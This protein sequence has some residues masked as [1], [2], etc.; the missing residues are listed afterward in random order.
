M[1]A[2]QPEYLLNLPNPKHLP[3]PHFI[4]PNTYWIATASGQDEPVAEAAASEDWRTALEHR[5]GEAFDLAQ[6]MLV[7]LRSTYFPASGSAALPTFGDV[8]MMRNAILAALRDTADFGLRYGPDGT[9]LLRFIL[10]RTSLD[11]TTTA[12]IETALVALT[13]FTLDEWTAL[14]I[15]CEICANSLQDAFSQPPTGVFASRGL[16]THVATPD[17]L[18]ATLDMLDSIQTALA[19]DSTLATVLLN[20][21][22]DADPTDFN[23]SFPSAGPNAT[24]KTVVAAVFDDLTQPPQDQKSVRTSRI[25]RRRMLLA[26]MGTGLPASTSLPIWM[27]LINTP[28]TGYQDEVADVTANLQSLL[29]SYFRGRF[30]ITLQDGNASL[31][32]GRLPSANWPGTATLPAPDLSAGLK[33]DAGTFATNVLFPDPDDQSQRSSHPVILQ[34]GDTTDAAGLKPVNDNERKVAGVGLLIREGNGLWTCADIANLYVGE[35]SNA[36][37]FTQ[38]ALDRIVPIRLHTRNKLKQP[39]LSYNNASL[40]TQEADPTTQTFAGAGT[41]S[42][43]ETTPDWDQLFQFRLDWNIFGNAFLGAGT[44]GQ[45]LFTI[46]SYIAP[47]GDNTDDWKR[48]PALKFGSTYSFLPFVIGNSGVLPP[49]LASLTNPFDPVSPRVFANNWPGWAGYIR[50]VKYLRRIGVGAPRIRAASADVQQDLPAIPP[51][52]VPLARDIDADS[53]TPVLLLYD[54]GTT[55]NVTS[56]FKLKLRPPACDLETWDRWVAGLGPTYRNTRIAI[57]TAVTSCTAKSVS[58][59]QTLDLSIDDPAVT[60]LVFS[61]V[62]VYPPPTAADVVN[63]VPISMPAL[64]AFGPSIT[65]PADQVLTTLM[66]PV[67]FDG[68]T[69][70]CSIDPTPALTPSGYGVIVTIPEGQVWKLSA[71]V[72]VK[73]AGNFEGLAAANLTRSFDLLIEAASADV[74]APSASPITL[75]TFQKTLCTA[76]QISYANNQLQASLNPWGLP[77]DAN[78]SRDLIR[79]IDLRRQ[80]WRWMGRPIAPLPA[81]WKITPPMSLLDA[82]PPDTISPTGPQCSR[83]WEIGSFAERPDEDSAINET[84]VNFAWP[85]TKSKAFTAI[86]LYSSDLTNDPRAQYFRF[87]IDVHSRYEGLPGFAVLPVRAQLNDATGSAFTRWMRAVVPPRNSGEIPKPKVLLILPLTEPDSTQSSALPDLLVIANEEWFAIGGLAEELHAELDLA[88]DPAVPLST[89]TANANPIPEL[90]PN[91]ILTATALNSSVKFSSGNVAPADPIGTTF[92]PGKTAALFGNTCFRLKSSMLNSAAPLYPGAAPSAG[93][94]HF[95]AKIRFRRVINA[96]PF[97]TGI[98]LQSDPTEAFH[99]E[100]QSSFVH[101]LTTANPPAVVRI[102][103]LTFA[104]SGGQL[105]FTSAGGVISLQAGPPVSSHLQLWALV[106]RTIKDVTGTDQTTAVDILGPGFT[107]SVPDSP[108]LVVYLLE[109]LISTELS[110]VFDSGIAKAASLLFPSPTSANPNPNA[111]ARINRCS[112]VIHHKL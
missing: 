73:E 77:G 31:F 75:A 21:W 91:P 17:Y 112:Q 48:I 46:P 2:I 88:R 70:E 60:G 33:S 62:R 37:T 12:T 109:V 32:A 67:Q 94:E 44:A 96:D 28:Q 61:L 41:V 7:L 45:F 18:R 50:T 104:V 27:A 38:L 72:N 78:T 52:V 108:D 43:P 107:T 36:G 105:Q 15:K 111:M 98:T 5:A 19:T 99:V 11:A 65:G 76:L 58:E 92:D 14:L 55:A 87:G 89:P 3:T 16:S 101:C 74:F 30:N 97:N 100:F 63:P 8:D 84:T 34:V 42:P 103:D 54:N 82:D 9:N 29:Q 81:D 53:Q 80:A 95:E 56:S 6:R 26:N 110:T 86:I 66:Q 49:L 13:T 71:A 20:Q 69:V 22:A 35:P 83:V 23:M 93:L 1:Q 68:F 85:S 64:T 79:H 25:L 106:M 40:V 4:D 24:V 90:G 47:T 51:T 57:A 102:G 10:Q 39:I 59:Q